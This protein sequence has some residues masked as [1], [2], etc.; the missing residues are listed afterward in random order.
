MLAIA[1][2]LLIN[3]RLLILDEPSQ[4]LAPL[5][6]KN[7]F[8][9]I[10]GMRKEGIAVLLAE[11]NVRASIALADRAYVLSDG[12][13]VFSGTRSEFTTDEERVQNLVGARAGIG[14]V[15]AP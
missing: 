15:R 6:V 10:S 14:L 5:I 11:Q 12:H 2:A 4:G 3:P 13:V 8:A 7:V 9:V 1:R